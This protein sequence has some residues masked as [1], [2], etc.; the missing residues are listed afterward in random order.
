LKY[1]ELAFAVN[2]GTRQ[3][4]QLALNKLSGTTKDGICAEMLKHAIRKRFCMPVWVLVS[5]GIPSD[6]PFDG[7]TAWTLFL[8]QIYNSYFLSSRGNQLSW[9]WPL[10]FYKA[11]PT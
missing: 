11:M 9:G 3:Q 2:C 4:T 6:I 8:H 7:Y 1:E 5:N 10:R